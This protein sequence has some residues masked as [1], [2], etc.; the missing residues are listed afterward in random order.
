[1]KRIVLIT[2]VALMV[3]AA[4]TA[5]AVESL[6]YSVGHPSFSS[7]SNRI[8]FASNYGGNSDIY[9][10][11]SDGSSLVRLTDGQ[12]DRSRPEWSPDGNYIAYQ[13]TDATGKDSIML[14]NADGSGAHS[15]TTGTYEEW[16]PAWLPNG[17]Q[18]LV[19]TSRNNSPDLLLIASSGSEV[20]YV[21]ASVEQEDSPSC[22]PDAA[23]VAYHVVDASEGLDGDK[24][25]LHIWK[26]SLT[27]ISVTPVQLTTGAYRD[28]DPKVSPS[29]GSIAFTTNRSG[30]G[31]AVY[32][33]NADGTNMAAVPTGDGE[34]FGPAWV[35]GNRIV[36][37]RRTYVEDGEVGL[38]D[39]CAVNLDGT[40]LTQ[41]THTVARPQCSPEAGTYSGTQTVTITSSPG[42]V[43]RYTTDG[44][45]PTESSPEYTQPISVN[46]SLTL[47]AKAWKT[48]WFPSHVRSGEYVIE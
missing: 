6:G 41:V 18:L 11:N 3:F 22:F 43:I 16:S 31:L 4:T 39:V 45:D 36:F 19:A 12:S 32:V 30:Y 25:R 17:N 46:Q 34:A 37:V 38:A 2:I 48:D 47:K 15:I 14:M 24:M 21:A 23:S 44:S 27:D 26:R 10:I 29:G 33:M 5:D 28:R 40:N 9:R 1:M 7:V 20:R 13:K 35:S 8:V 42:A